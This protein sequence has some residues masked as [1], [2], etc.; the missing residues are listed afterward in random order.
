MEHEYLYCFG[1]HS[2]SPSYLFPKRSRR[3]ILLLISFHHDLFK[4]CLQQRHAPFPYTETR[5][6][7]AKR[8]SNVQFYVTWLNFILFIPG[9][10]LGSDCKISDAKLP[11]WIC[12][13]KCIFISV[14]GTPENEQ[15]GGKLF[16]HS[17]NYWTHISRID[18]H[19]VYAH[20][21]HTELLEPQELSVGTTVSRSPT[22]PQVSK[23][24]PKGGPLRLQYEMQ[25]S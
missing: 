23:D 21:R 20:S 25:K 2:M 15:A 12:L 18:G 22:N 1:S 3:I 9:A 7:K 13:C 24:S 11:N 19:L 17:R 4:I 5:L 10:S 16:F 6:W 14:T 8:Y